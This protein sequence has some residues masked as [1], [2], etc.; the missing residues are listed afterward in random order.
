MNPRELILKHIDHIVDIVRYVHLKKALTSVNDSP[1]LNFWRVIYGGL[2]DLAVLSWCK[3]YGSNAEPTH[4]KELVID[5]EKFRSELLSTLDIDSKTWADYW[6]HMKYY[7]NEYIAHDLDEK[8]VD[9]F[10]TLDLA[11]ESCYFFITII[12]IKSL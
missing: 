7:R 2:L 4:W 3:L 10:P 9:T 11:L 5:H 12:Y 8:I 6:N 1:H